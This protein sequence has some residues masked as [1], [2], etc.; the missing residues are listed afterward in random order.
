MLEHVCC[1]HTK[2]GERCVHTKVEERRHRCRCDVLLST[3]L[4]L[5]WSRDGG[6]GHDEAVQFVLQRN[7]GDVL[8]MNDN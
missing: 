3:S 6:V 7:G 8:C 5:T 4:L 1:M 2:A